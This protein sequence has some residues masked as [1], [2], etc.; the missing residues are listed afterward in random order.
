MENLPPTPLAELHRHH[1]TSHTPSSLFRV[2]NLLGIQRFQGLSVE[3]IREQIQA[4][5][6]S[7]FDTWHKYLNVVREAYISPGAVA[8]LTADVMRDGA[9][10]GLDLLE[11]RISLLSTTDCIKRQ[12]QNPQPFWTIARE[13]LDAILEIRRKVEVEQHIA[14]DLILSISCQTKYLSYVD[15]YVK[16]MKDYASDIIAIDLTNEK[17]N[18]PTAYRAAIDRVRPSIEFLTI[19]CMETMGPQRGWMSLELCPNRIGHGIRAVEDPRLIDEIRRRGIVLEICPL[20]N[21]LTGVATKES[22][23]FRRLAEAGLKL[24]INH[25]GL[26]D[27]RTLRDD[28]DFLRVN[29]RYS[30]T[31]MATF[32]ENAWQAAFRNWKRSQPCS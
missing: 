24:T 27:A 22:H 9:R 23:P 21:L 14:I 18:P 7:D 10:E 19:H 26:N 28:Y 13:V 15:D 4:P 20:S 25:D 5:D 30:D 17:E 16:L 32:R 6:G 3:Q 31:E 11:L 12:S 8:E 1:D 29:F 2:A